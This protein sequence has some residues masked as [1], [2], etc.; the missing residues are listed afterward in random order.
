[1]AKKIER[2]AICFNVLDDYQALMHKWITDKPNSSGYLK[3][4]IQR[5]MEG[6]YLPPSSQQATQQNDFDPNGF[7]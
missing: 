1:M 2:V 3:R 6:G 7:L 5:D 4:L